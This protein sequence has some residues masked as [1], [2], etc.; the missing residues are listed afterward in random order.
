MNK[1]FPLVVAL[2]FTLSACAI[3]STNNEIDDQTGDNPNVKFKVVAQGIHSNISLV[4]QLVIKTKAD[5]NRLLKIHAGNNATSLATID[6]ND[7]IVITVFAGQQPS[8]G[9]SV[10][11]SKIKKVDDNLYV[12]LTFTEPKQGD[13]VTLATTQPFI[14]LSTEKVEGK[15]IFLADKL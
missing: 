3:P 9:Y 15:I 12:S 10:G 14:F 4:S 5:W 7:D 11:V 8:G 13:P 1:L 6:F 2:L